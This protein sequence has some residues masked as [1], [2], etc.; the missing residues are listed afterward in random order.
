ME[1][2]IELYTR[3][4]VT[5]ALNGE[6]RISK[7]LIDHFSTSNPKSI[8]K[9]DMLETGMVDHYMV[10][11]I[12]KANAWRYKREKKGPKTIEFRNMKKYDSALFLQDLQQIDWKTI[13]D[14]LTDDPSGMADTFQEIFEST[15]DFHSPIKR[16]KYE[17]NSLPG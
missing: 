6:K 3:G 11:G 7:S 5:T 15:L 9:T 8:L 13:L 10:D 14:H 17:W 4:A 1:Q 12:R 2:L 16:K